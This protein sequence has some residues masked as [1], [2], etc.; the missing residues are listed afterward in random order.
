MI[1]YSLTVPL[2][3]WAE[4]GDSSS[5]AVICFVVCGWTGLGWTPTVACSHS[6][7][8][9]LTS[10]GAQWGLPFIAPARDP[11]LVTCASYSLSRDWMFQETQA[12]APR[13]LWPRTPLVLFSLGHK[14]HRS[15]PRSREG[16]W[17]FSFDM[18]NIK[19][20]REGTGGGHLWRPSSV[21]GHCHIL[22]TDHI[23]LFNPPSPDLSS[24]LELGDDPGRSHCVLA[25]TRPSMT[26][27]FP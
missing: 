13:F 17:D 7:Q 9:I 22:L 26:C 23:S 4:L 2:A 1:S 10:V 20:G 14:S 21:L 16:P 8:L 12:E 19:L 11:L 18:R 25:I 15:Q 3:D 27:S 5:R 24:P 6:W